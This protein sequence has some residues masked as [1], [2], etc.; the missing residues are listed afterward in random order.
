[1]GKDLSHIS[2]N[3]NV[4]IVVEENLLYT[5]HIEKFNLGNPI[6]YIL[7]SGEEYA[8]AFTVDRNHIS[9]FENI[10]SE[11]TQI[12]RIGYVSDGFGVF[13]KKENSELIDIS[14]LGFEHL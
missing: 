11:H 9:K 1:M 3:S 13:L 4:K 10:M 12:H 7:T 8:L 5:K 14:K 2:E 6:D